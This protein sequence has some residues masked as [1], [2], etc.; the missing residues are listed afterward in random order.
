MEGLEADRE[1]GGGGSIIW[2]QSSGI[3]ILARSEGANSDVSVTTLLRLLSVGLGHMSGWGGRRA[4][5]SGG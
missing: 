1:T 4:R 3:A 2:L 5:A